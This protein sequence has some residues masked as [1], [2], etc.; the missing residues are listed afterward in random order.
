MLTVVLAVISL[1]AL[2]FFQRYEG[3]RRFVAA[4]MKG[5]PRRR[6]PITSGRARVLATLGGVVFAL[7]LALPVLTLLM[8]SFAREGSWTTET[9][10]TAY[11][12]ENYARILTEEER[13]SVLFNSL[14]MSGIAAVC[15]LVWSFC[16]A[17]LALATAL[18]REKDS[19]AFDTRAV[20]FAGNRGCRLN[21]R[22]LRAA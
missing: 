5:A 18:S 4:T 17:S 9:L 12:F 8:V 16:A 2:L 1:G 11:T 21:R 19:F 3:T 7:V 22:G 15:A 6:R 20:G 10:P 14:L 13:L